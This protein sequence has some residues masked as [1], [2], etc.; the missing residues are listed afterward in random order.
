VTYFDRKQRPNIFLVDG[1][2]ADNI[3]ARRIIFEVAESGGY[4]ELAETGQVTL[5]EAV[6]YIVVNA[7]AGGHHGWAQR[8]SDPS[9]ATVLGAISSVGIYRYNFETVELLR[10]SAKRWSEAARKHGKRLDTFV[11]E[12]AFD[13]LED[14]KE[15]AYF[16]DVETSF[17]LSDEKV[18]RLIE[19]G[20]RLL[21]ES[22]EFEKFLAQH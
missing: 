18:D 9:L 15:R 17:S 16:N 6:L 11:V 21:R 7:Q 22:K 20:G 2:V 12:V 10:E 1:G 4:L 5:P 13:S 19:V 14:P 3:G 8:A